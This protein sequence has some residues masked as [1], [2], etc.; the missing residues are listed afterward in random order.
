MYVLLLLAAFSHLT[1]R[2]I[3]LYNT[4]VCLFMGLASHLI[5]PVCSWA[6]RKHGISWL[7][8]EGCAFGLSTVAGSAVTF[9][10]ELCSFGSAR[11]RWSYWL[12]SGVQCSLILFLWCSLYFSI[13]QWKRSLEAYDRL[14]RAEADVRSAQ[15]RALQHQINPH[16]LF[17]SLNAV[18]TLVLEGRGEDAN[19]MI[20][21][22]CEFLRTSLTSEPPIQVCLREEIASIKRYLA[23]EQV[24][25]GERLTV[26]FAMG[27]EVMDA[28]VPNMILQPVLENAIKHGIA[29]TSG[30]GKVLVK[31]HRYDGR[32][33]LEIRNSG[34]V[35]LVSGGRSGTP[36]V[37]LSNTKT[38]LETLYGSAHELVFLR[39]EDGGFEVSITMPYQLNKEDQRK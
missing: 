13:K 20:E 24:R 37:G 33:Q 6:I 27:S 5:R 25:F 29:Q 4:L 28:L 14:L 38:R 1:E 8:W 11:F 15:L 3:F 26:D 22:I 32:L 19:Q 34:D 23:I 16:L 9:L 35:Q 30:P 12:L 10:T 7:A 17:N 31:A 18:S 2:D 39:P 21:Q 36:G